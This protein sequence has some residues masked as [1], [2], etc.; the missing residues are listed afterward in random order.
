[1]HFPWGFSGNVYRKQERIQTHDKQHI[2][3]LHP[4]HL[5]GYLPSS[6]IVC[7]QGMLLDSIATSR[8]DHFAWPRSSKMLKSQVSRHGMEKEFWAIVIGSQT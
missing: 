5:G 2:S 7:L 4:P 3:G 8:G 6:V 1:M